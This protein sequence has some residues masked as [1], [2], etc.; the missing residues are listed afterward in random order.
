M[1]GARHGGAELFFERLAIAFHEAGL[2]QRLCIKPH[3]DRWNRL[4][5]AGLELQQSGYHPPLRFFERSRINKMIRNFDADIILSWM[6]RATAFMP[7]TARPHIG[8]LGGFY[9]LKYYRNCDW[10]VA[11]TKGIADYLIAAG[12]P[13]ARTHYQANFVPDGKD[14]TPLARPQQA[15]DRLVLAALGRLH[16]NKGFDTLIKALV[17]HKDMFL[18]LAGDG[19]EAAALK[20][21]AETCGLAGRIAFLGWQEQPQ[22]VIRAADIFVCPSRHE[23]FGNVIAEAFATETPVIATASK[24]ACELIAPDETGLLV[25]VDDVRAL[26]DAIG[27]LAADKRAREQLAAA[28]YKLWQQRF[29]RR[30]VTANWLA[31]LDGVR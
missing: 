31:F 3:G 13:A 17:P 14:I 23:P 29:T 15:G 28:G 20:E 26:S 24:G 19:P 6:N 9:D 16:V 1:A 4:E 25:P 8:R 2:E 5:E 10:L 21:L 12:W 30:A 22:A 18:L 7:R 11:N 27:Q